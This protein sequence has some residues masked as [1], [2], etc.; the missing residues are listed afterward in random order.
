[1]PCGFAD[2][3]VSRL[4]SGSC[5]ERKVEILVQA[6]KMISSV[7]KWH[8]LYAMSQMT[9]MAEAA[10][11]V[12]AEVVPEAENKL[13]SHCS[14]ALPCLVKPKLCSRH[15]CEGLWLPKVPGLLLSA[16]G[17]LLSVPE[18]LVMS[19]GPSAKAHDWLSRA[20][21][22][23]ASVLGPLTA[24]KTPHTGQGVWVVSAGC[25]DCNTK[26]AAPCK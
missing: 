8:M 19:L 12:A 16:L 5:P 13:L 24:S 18:L 11:Q 15:P 22:E 20:L 4:V 3:H 7:D 26:T 17:L 10:A 9:T 23:P 6:C 1:M 14:E 21:P 2:G 25:K